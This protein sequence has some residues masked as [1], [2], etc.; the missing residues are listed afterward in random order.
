MEGGGERKYDNAHFVPA[1]KKHITNALTA[2]KVILWETSNFLKGAGKRGVREG[3]IIG[4]Q[5][6]FL[7][8][9]GKRGLGTFQVG[10]CI[11]EKGVGKNKTFA[12]SFLMS[13][14]IPASFE[15]IC[16]GIRPSFV[17]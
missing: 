1:K 7:K 8:G 14:Q 6:T 11:L 15:I 13:L 2:G 4:R 17:D 10:S 5:A 3:N 12:L 16:Y 9:A